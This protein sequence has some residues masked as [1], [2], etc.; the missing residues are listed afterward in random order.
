MHE[1]VETV[2]EF[3]PQDCGYRCY[4]EPHVHYCGYAL[5]ENKPRGCKISECDK[6]TTRKKKVTMTYD[7]LWF[8]W[9]LEEYEYPIIR[10]APRGDEY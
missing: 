8:K 1:E 4:L 7:G 10:Q 6:Y 2:E 9:E 3:C 5:I